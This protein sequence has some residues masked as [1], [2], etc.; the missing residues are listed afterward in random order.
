MTT[1]YVTTGLPGC[2]KTSRARELDALRFNLDD[3][4]ASMGVTRETWNRE[5]EDVAIATMLTGAKAAIAAGF[6]VVLDNT[7][8]VPRLPR[9]YRKELGRLGVDFE[10]IDCTDVSIEECIE[11][12]SLRADPVGEEVI[13]KLAERHAE[14]G[15]NGWRLTTE[16]LTAGAYVLPKPYEARPDMPQ[17]VICDLDGTVALNDGHRGHY[18]YEKVGNDAP[19]PGVIRIVQAFAEDHAVIF[20]SGRE[21]RC[22]EE[23]EQWLWLHGLSDGQNALYMRTTG[24]H[25]PD[26]VIKGELFDAH[27]RDRFDVLAVLDDR[28]QVVKLWRDMGLTCLQVADG[29]F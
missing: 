17:I 21:D 8:L 13:R 26:Y 11:R 4:R 24:D 19:N 20:M 10:V 7:H 6:D 16:W 28:D 15:K 3:M 18:E 23:T 12:D 27:I 25:R 5:R 1:V 2:G 22:R 29:D 14:A 9:L